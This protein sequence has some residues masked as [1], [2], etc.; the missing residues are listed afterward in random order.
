MTQPSAAALRAAQR[1]ESAAREYI[2]DKHA[3]PDGVLPAEA[4]AALIDREIQ[5]I[6]D[7]LRLAEVWLANCLPIGEPTTEKPLPS[8]RAALQ[9]YEGER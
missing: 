2:R 1:I 9:H 5:P 3:A 8:L 6:V 7:A 4:V